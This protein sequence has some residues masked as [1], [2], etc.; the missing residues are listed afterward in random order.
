MS[1]SGC[2]RSEADYRKLANALPQIIWT[3]D[4][5]G[6]L[7]WVNDRWVELTGL[8]E[9]QSLRDKGALAAVHPDDVDELQRQFA[10][11]IASAAPCEVEYR[12][13]TRAGVY[14]YHLCRVVPMRDDQEVITRWVAAAFD[15][16]ERRQAEEALR[17]AERR[18]DEFLVLLSHELRNPL[19]PIL[20]AAEL[21]L[22]K[23]EVATP[24]ECEVILR[25]A[26]HMV[27]LLDDLLPPAGAP[28]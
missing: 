23:G 27:R 25:Q 14:R 20:S 5:D 9:E 12:I 6:R 8:G 15:I 2:D 10:Q 21:M 26:Q 13:R 16:H 11:A 22:L 3:C 17:E 4:A 18:N 24:R 7:A 1:S 19:A 28:K